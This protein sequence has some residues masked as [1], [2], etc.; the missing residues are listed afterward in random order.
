MYAI[1]EDI[2]MEVYEISE[3]KLLL[4][5]DEE[6]LEIYEETVIMEECTRR[7]TRPVNATVN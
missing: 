4:I 7:F 2:L 1:D 5:S 6:L 3:Q